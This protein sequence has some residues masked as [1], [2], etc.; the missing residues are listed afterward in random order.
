VQG[1]KR[2]KRKNNSQI[3]F[4]KKVNFKE[5]ETRKKDNP[6][7]SDRNEDGKRISSDYIEQ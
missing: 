1:R 5:K 4:L 6:K 2:N 3:L 7:L